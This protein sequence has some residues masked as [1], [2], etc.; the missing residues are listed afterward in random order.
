MPECTLCGQAVPDLES[1]LKSTHGLA[2][3]QLL[4]L[5]KTVQDERKLKKI[6]RVLN[7]RWGEP[8]SKRAKTEQPV[9]THIAR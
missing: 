6:K 9:T 5:F 2:L 8:E 4:D 3:K 7:D 1:H